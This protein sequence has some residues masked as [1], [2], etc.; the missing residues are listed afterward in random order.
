VAAG[1]DQAEPVVLDRSGRR[2]RGVV[3][4]PPDQRHRGSLAGG[5]LGDVQVAEA[6]GK[7]GDH[8]RPLLTVDPGERP[9]DRHTGHD[10][11]IAS[12]DAAVWNGRTSTVP[13]HALDPSA[14]IA[15]ASSRSAASMT[16]KPPRYSFASR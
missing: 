10:P 8:P 11:S 4:R 1:E 16:Q 2:G 6:A 9:L 5:I 14:A 3:A 7:A 12:T 13:R 15:R